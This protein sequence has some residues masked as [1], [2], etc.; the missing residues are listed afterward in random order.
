MPGIVGFRA[1]AWHSSLA[2]LDFGRLPG[3][4]AWHSWISGVCLAF[5]PGIV[6]FRAFAWH[7][8]LA[9]ILFTMLPGIFPWH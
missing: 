7:S 3:I 8:C 5:F 9:L 6:G 4:L 2:F 1:L